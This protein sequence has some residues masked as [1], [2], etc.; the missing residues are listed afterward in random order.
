MDLLCV[1]FVA[2]F[3]LVGGGM[4][5]EIGNKAAEE[6]EEYKNALGR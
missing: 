4:A 3:L 2:L 6:A 5:S 1:A